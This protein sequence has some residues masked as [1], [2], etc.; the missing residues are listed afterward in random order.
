[1]DTS[2]FRGNV[3]LLG[4]YGTNPCPD[5]TQYLTFDQEIEKNQNKNLFAKTFDNIKNKITSLIFGEANAY[6]TVT[7]TSNFCAI[8]GKTDGYNNVAGQGVLTFAPNRA[9]DGDTRHYAIILGD[10]DLFDENPGGVLDQ[11]GIGMGI[12]STYV[13]ETFNSRDYINSYIWSFVTLSEQGE[14]Q[15]IC[16]IDYIDIDPSSYLFQ[17]TENSLVEDDTN[18]LANSFDNE[19]DSDKLFVATAKTISGQ[20]LNPIASLYTWAW[21]W[22]MGN[23]SVADFVI[24]ASLSDD[25]RLVRAQN[26]AVE[27][28]TVAEATATVTGSLALPGETHMGDADIYLF[29]CNNPWPPISTTVPTVGQWAPWQDQTN[30]CT[31]LPEGAG[32]CANTNYEFYYCRDQGTESTFDDLPPILNDAIIR[33][34]DTD[35]NLFKE[36]YFFREAT[37][38]LSSIA[39]AVSSVP[40]LGESVDIWWGNFV[41][42]IGEVLDEFLIYYGTT[43]GNY[44]NT[45]SVGPFVPHTLVTPV[46]ISDLDNGQVYYFSITAV[47]ESG[48]ESDFSNEIIATPLDTQDPVAPLIINAAIGNAEA[49]VEWNPVVDV[50]SYKLYWKAGSGCGGSTPPDCYA[51]SQNVGDAVAASITDLT[52]GTM[53]YFAAT[54]I[55]SSGNESAYSNEVTVIPAVTS[56]TVISGATQVAL[57]W[58]SANLVSQDDI[59]YIDMGT[60]AGIFEE[61]KEIDGNRI[62]L[63]G[64]IIKYIIK[65]ISYTFISSAEAQ[66]G[67]IRIPLCS[68]SPGIICREQIIEANGSHDTV[69]KN[70]SNGRKYRFI[71]KNGPINNQEVVDDIIVEMKD[72]EAAQG[73]SNYGERCDANA[74]CGGD[75]ICKDSGRDVTEKYCCKLDECASS[76]PDNNPV[77]HC[78]GDNGVDEGLDPAHGAYLLT[79]DNG[80]WYSTN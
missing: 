71:I 79:C 17:T 4:D 9:L 8:R 45:V 41:P 33:G 57:G 26:S 73:I 34:R 58:I 69:I 1:M 20:S 36:Y 62:N 43:S 29:L 2:T 38:D 5:G 23:T 46:N 78:V 7:S 12:N 47:Y 56:A 67:E 19:R 80:V 76:L 3:V 30:N 6:Q 54:A 27:G 25:K 10:D 55:D 68:T 14:N 24:L 63:F 50:S 70:L 49:E 22:M 15:G 42:D 61:Y 11:F 72:T 37:P 59:Y 75:L 44:T 35:Q 39:L 53:Y 31:V 51:N 18:P 74:S 21:T 32:T 65:K 60:I 48:A 52:N 16:T 66:G 13:L 77:F 28:S 40:T 64:D